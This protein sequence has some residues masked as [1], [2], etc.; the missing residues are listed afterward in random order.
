MSQLCI[1]D[2]LARIALAF[3]AAVRSVDL[4]GA[5]RLVRRLCSPWHLSELGAGMGAEGA[6]IKH[7]QCTQL[8]GLPT[9][10]QNTTPLKAP[11]EI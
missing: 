8:A 11:A 5:G 7:S 6:D 10:L 3:A 2:L 9:R 1:W 4:E